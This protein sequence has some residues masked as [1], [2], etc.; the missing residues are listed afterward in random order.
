VSSDRLARP[1]FGDV[2][3]VGC[4]LTERSVGPAGVVVLD[5]L[6]EESFEMRTV[7]D[8]RAIGKF[9]AHGADPTL[10]ECVRDGDAD[11]YG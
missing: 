5:V 7:P 3:F 10:R 1:V 9:A 6:A 2:A 11:R 4:A 8:E